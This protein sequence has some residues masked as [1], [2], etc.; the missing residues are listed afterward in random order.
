LIKTYILI[1]EQSNIQYIY[2]TVNILICDC[3]Y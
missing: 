1:E 2:K 3:F